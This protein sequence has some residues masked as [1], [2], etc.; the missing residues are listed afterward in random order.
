MAAPIVIGPKD[1]MLAK[2][3]WPFDRE[4][5]I[6]EP[7]FDGH[8]SIAT[9]RGSHVQLMS[10]SGND[11]SEWYG[12]VVAELGKVPGSWVIDGEVCVLD[13]AGIPDFE[14]LQVSVRS[15]RRVPCA[16]FAFDLLV[17][18]GR[19]LRTLPLLDRKARLRKLVTGRSAGVGFVDHLETD[20]EAFFA[21]MVQLGMEGIVAKRA[22]SPYV[23]GYSD[24]WRKIKPAGVH[25]GWKRPLRRRTAKAGK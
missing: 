6:W 18:N 14:A 10:R 22:D 4:R 8:R 1:L 23:A 20:G 11:S 21:G 3:G 24:D 15:R 12:G 9:K 16:Y 19:D 17:L 25:D 5:H 2:K 13:E 7:K